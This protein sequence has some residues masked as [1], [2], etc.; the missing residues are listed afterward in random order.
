MQTFLQG[1]FGTFACLAALL[2]LV[3][4]DFCVYD[5]IKERRLSFPSFLIG[6]GVV[7]L[8]G[9]FAYWFIYG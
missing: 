3:I 4:C 8:M 5:D 1:A 2:F 7:S 6:M 9:G